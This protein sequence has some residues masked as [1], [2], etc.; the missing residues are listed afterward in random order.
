MSAWTRSALP[1]STLRQLRSAVLQAAVR[2]RRSGVHSRA[3]PRPPRSRRCSASRRRTSAFR[4]RSLSVDRGVVSGGGKN[5]TYGELVDGK[6]F[7]LAIP[8]H[9]QR[10]DLG[11]FQ[12]LL[13][14]GLEPGEAPAKPID[15][16]KLVGRPQPRVDVPG[17]V[18]ATLAYSGDV[19]L[20]GMLHGRVVR[21]Q[22]QSSLLKKRTPGGPYGTNYT[23]ELLAGGG[24]AVLSVDEARS[25]TSP[26]RKSCTSGTSSASSPP[27]NGARSKQHSS[28]RCAGRNHRRRCRGTTTWRRPE[29]CE[30]RPSGVDA[31]SGPGVAVAHNGDGRCR[32]RSL[33]SGEDGVRHLQD[34]LSASRSGRAAQRGRGRQRHRG[35]DLPPV[36]PQLRPCR[37]GRRSGGRAA[38]GECAGDL[39]SGIELLRRRQH[40]PRLPHGSSGAVKGRREAGARPIHALGRH[41]VRQLRRCRGDRCPC[42]RRCERKDQRVRLRRLQP[43]RTPLSPPLPSTPAAST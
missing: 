24:Q 16:Y 32:N 41:G 34:V 39:V 15:Q 43:G 6:L 9:V 14:P 25:S 28:S 42:R 18:T 29:G 40:R 12:H 36:R 37:T 23:L 17:I 11:V 4:L 1:V 7:D 30:A 8:Q 13:R 31:H 20:P 3:Q 35:D 27:T 10:N 33:A 22:G 5:V 2:G 26:G 19:R 38:R 21:P